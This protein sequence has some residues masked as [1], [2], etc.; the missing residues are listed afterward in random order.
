MGQRSGKALCWWEMGPLR[1]GSALCPLPKAVISANGSALDIQIAKRSVSIA[2]LRSDGEQKG[3][4]LRGE[5]LRALRSGSGV[6]ERRSPV[7]DR[8]TEHQLGG[9]A[10]HRLVPRSP[11]RGAAPC[12]GIAGIRAERRSFFVPFPLVPPPPP[13]LFFSPYLVSAEFTLVEN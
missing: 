5:R 2:N 1:L 4:T 6:G 12:V 13:S 3:R 11:A 7:R 8:S 9:G 10:Q